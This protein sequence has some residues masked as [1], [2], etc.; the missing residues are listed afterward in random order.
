VHSYVDL[1]ERTLQSQLLHLLA[2]G[3]RPTRTGPG[4]ANRHGRTWSASQATWQAFGEAVACVK[5]ASVAEG[6]W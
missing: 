5:L 4:L 1:A 6:G 3:R 2:E